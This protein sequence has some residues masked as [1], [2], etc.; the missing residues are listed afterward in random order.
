MQGRRCN[1]QVK[2][3]ASYVWNVDTLASRLLVVQMVL[4][5]LSCLA[6][7]TSVSFS[8]RCEDYLMSLSNLTWRDA[9][10]CWQIWGRLS[11]REVKV[12]ASGASL[13]T[14][15]KYHKHQ[16]PS[17][18]TC[19]SWCFRVSDNLLQQ[20]RDHSGAYYFFLKSEQPL[21]GQSS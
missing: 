9:L 20:P 14:V 18:F 10:C 21:G 19:H 4:R 5:W 12:K 2:Q 8:L 3:A 17:C 16:R 7:D 1:L 6:A 11:C 13:L 15:D